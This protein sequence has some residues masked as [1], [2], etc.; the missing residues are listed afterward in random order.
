MYVGGLDIGTSGCKVVVFDAN[1][2]QIDCVYREYDVKRQRGLHEIDAFSVFESVKA[3]LSEISVKEIHAL[4]VTSFGETF[5][6]LDE[7]DVPCAPSMLYTDPRGKAEC[8]CLIEKFGAETLAF[9]TGAKPHEMYSLPKIMWVKNNMPEHYAKARA[10]LLMQDF[11]VYMLSGKRQIDYSLAARTTLFDITNKC[12]D[13]EIAKFCGIDLT[14]MSEPV[15][16][17]TKAGVIKAHIAKEL[18]LSEKL[19]I[20]SGCHDQIAAMTGAGVFEPEQ[21]MDGTGTV[22][23]VPVIMDEVPKDMSLF[24]YGYSIAPHINGKYACYVLSYA[25]GATL[26]WFRDT[27]SGTS[28]AQMDKEVSDR[29][30]DIMIMPHF[31]GAATPYM[32]INAKAAMLGITFEHDKFD[33][34]KALMEGTAYE[35]MLNLDLLSEF[36]IN[37]QNLIATGGGAR[38]DVWLQIKADVL[39][40]PVTALDGDEIGAAGTAFLAGRAISDTGYDFSSQ[41]RKVFYP[42]KERNEFYKKQFRKYKK[43]YSAVKMVMADE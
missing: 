24:E 37:P 15:P 32:D 8:H 28:Y 29:P 35:I 31:A 5:V 25:G 2:K 43:I 26:K 34:Y 4:G 40:I 19:M 10:I 1:G 16:S 21:V 11:I 14:L 12:W 23:C 33:I 27:F 36:G 39:G 22:E 13:S 30:T 6:M 9:K 20:V 17:G 41:I 7:N 3:V 42:N 38:S 18:G